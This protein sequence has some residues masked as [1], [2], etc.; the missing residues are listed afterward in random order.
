MR[1]LVDESTG[2][3]VARWLREEGHEIFSV[4]EEARGIDDDEVIERAFLENRILITNDK[5]F[6]E[7]VYREQRPH[8]GVV[9]LRL[10]DERSANKINTIRRLLESYSQQLGDNFVV[11]T[12]TQV[13]FARL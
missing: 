6:G 5:D 13:R 12:E 9:L 8:K 2:P 10:E 1:F 11:V 7:K 3:A 4:Y